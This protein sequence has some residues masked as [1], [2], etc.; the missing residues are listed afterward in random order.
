MAQNYSGGAVNDTIRLS[1][2]EH[3]RTPSAHLN[4]AGWDWRLRLLR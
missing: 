3:W 4:W 1:N 2:G